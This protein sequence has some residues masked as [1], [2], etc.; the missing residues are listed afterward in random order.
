MNKYLALTIATIITSAVIGG[1][2]GWFFPYP[3]ETPTQVTET[4]K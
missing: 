2:L 1:S 3:N 4:A